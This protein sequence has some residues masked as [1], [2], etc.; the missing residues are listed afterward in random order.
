[1]TV[2]AVSNPAVYPYSSVVAVTVTYSFGQITTGSGVLIGQNDVLTSAHLFS[3]PGAGFA[4]GITVTAASGTA[5]WATLNFNSLTYSADGSLD[6][7]E[8][9]RDLAVIG[10]DRALGQSAGWFSMS[11][12]SGAVLIQTAGFPTA[13]GGMTMV[14]DTTTA[15]FAVPGTLQHTAYATQGSAGAP[16]WQASGS[17]TVVGVESSTT[18]DVHYAAALTASNITTITAWQVSNETAHTGTAAAE[19]MS[20]GN[21]A[22]RAFA[23]DG[24]DTLYGGTGNDLLYGQVGND[25]QHGDDGDDA[26]DGGLGN[27]TLYGGSGA[28]A[29][30]G[31]QGSDVISGEDGND[32]ILSGD[33]NDTIFG[34]AGDDALRGQPGD[35]VIDAGAGNDRI[36]GDKGS[37]TLTGGAGA[38]SFNF[39]VGAGAAVITDFSAAQG[40][41]I[42]IDAGMTWTVASDGS[43]N[44]VITFSGGAQATLQGISA[45]AVVSDWFGL[46]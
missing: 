16:L 22:D 36:W 7:T 35:D 26:M 27:D 14:T 8:S 43:G 40:D 1:M 17:P 38:D 21:A 11:A 19:L 10:L 29:L 24:N 44:A 3:M 2:Q 39:F 46:A 5:S 41:R 12:V 30:G 4:T 13:Y 33:D 32:Y 34:G 37:N 31:A 20:F 9:G 15:S 28:D 18:G 25:E 42:G 45:S 23:G 6:V